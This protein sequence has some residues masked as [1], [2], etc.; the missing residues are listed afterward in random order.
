MEVLYFVSLFIFALYILVIV[1][2]FGIPKS[3]SESA[4]LF[5]KHG[6][7]IFY[8]AFMAF[9]VPLLIYWLEITTGQPQQALV[10]LS[11]GALC[12]TGISG[13]FK[14]DEGQ[15]PR[16]I[17]LY[18]VYVAILLSQVWMW[19]SVPWSWIWMIIVLPIMWVV[20]RIVPGSYRDRIRGNHGEWVYLSKERS[21]T[22]YVFWLEIGV[23]ILT[24][25]SVKLFSN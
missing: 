7:I 11:C 3:I 22:S 2:K 23:F 21:K 8:V 14:G 20:G 4:Y 17:H 15:M 18:S 24:Y 9:I 12:F 1:A 10:F 25:L 19:T 16:K 13:R 6:H 5:G